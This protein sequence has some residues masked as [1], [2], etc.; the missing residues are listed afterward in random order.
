MDVIEDAL[1]RSITLF[2]AIGGIMN[3]GNCLSAVVK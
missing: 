1:P 2:G 3:G